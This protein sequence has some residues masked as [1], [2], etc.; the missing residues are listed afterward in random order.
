MAPLVP[1]QRLACA[2]AA[3]RSGPCARVCQEQW[4]DTKVTCLKCI[5]ARCEE[6]N[7]AGEVPEE[8]P[9][10]KQGLP[11]TNSSWNW[12]TLVAVLVAI[13]CVVLWY[14]GIL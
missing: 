8:A 4:H 13:L 14:I 3:R 5:A 1:G 10:K 2:D 7:Y 12:I 9:E 11:A 6:T